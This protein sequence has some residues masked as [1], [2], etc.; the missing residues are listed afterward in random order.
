MRSTPIGSWHVIAPVEIV[1]NR[2]DAVA[3]P[4]VDQTSSGSAPT[5]QAGTEQSVP[6]AKHT[7]SGLSH[8]QSTISADG[9]PNSQ[10]SSNINED[11][12]NSPHRATSKS[13]LS[14]S[15]S[16]STAL[17]LVSA[18]EPAT[19]KCILIPLRNM[20]VA[21][22]PLSE[23]PSAITGN[24]I[25]V[26]SQTLTDRPSVNSSPRAADANL[27]DPEPE[28]GEKA[29]NAKALPPSQSP[30]S[31]VKASGDADA[32]CVPPRSA[33]PTRDVEDRSTTTQIVELTTGAPL[34]DRD[35]Q[36]LPKLES[37]ERTTPLD[38]NNLDSGWPGSKHEVSLPSSPPLHP[39]PVDATALRRVPGSSPSYGG[40]VFIHQLTGFDAI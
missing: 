1:S 40:M 25:G 14:F 13:R 32:N 19:P 18:N 22:G 6:E 37:A 4:E 26:A 3:P 8:A 11:E 34:L 30:S 15:S 2:P 7:S 21:R 9:V 35:D 28:V 24:S 31:R 36:D 10:D 20:P 5:L 12:I 29:T 33:F 16:S 38:S 23:N 39:S 27:V 17:P